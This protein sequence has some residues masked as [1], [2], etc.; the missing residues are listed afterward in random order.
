MAGRDHPWDPAGLAAVAAGGAVLV[1]GPPGCG[2]S[3]LVAALADA[4]GGARALGLDPGNPAFGPPGA[5]AL[6]RRSAGRWRLER[7]AALC[8]LDAARFR[9]PL[10]EAARSLRPE[11]AG[12][13]LVDLPGLVR[14]VAA[15]ELLDAAVRLL[16]VAAVIWV[17]EAAGLGAEL[18]ALG[19]P[20]WRVAAPPGAHRAPPAERAR[21]RTARWARWLAGAAART[22]PWAGLRAVGTPPPLGPA[23]RGLQIGFLADGATVGL[24]EVEAADAEGLRVRVAGRT[25]PTAL[26]RDAARAPDGLLRTRARARAAAVA[27][28]APDLRPGRSAAVPGPAFRVGALDALLVNGVFGDPLLHARLRHR[29]RSL[30]F[31]LGDGARLPARIAHQ[32]TDVFVSHAH[33]DHIAGLL[34]LLRA[35]MGEAGVCRLYGPAGVA[36]HVAAQLAA[37]LW[38]RIGEG[39]PRFEVLELAEGRLR[40]FALRAGGGGP[41]LI[42]EAP[43]PDGVVLEEAGLRVRAAV[44]DHGTPVLAYAFEP[45]REVHVRRDRLAA[46]GLAPGPW[47]TELKQAV[48]AGRRGAVIALPGGGVRSAG[49]L[50]RELLL[51][52]PPR[53]LVYA[54]DLADTASNRARLV[55]LAQ[56]A[57]TLVCEAAFLEAD[58]AQAEATGHLT[59]RA[60]GEIAAAAAVARLLPFHFSR[61]YED[62][63]EAVYDEVRAAF[64][65]E[66]LAT[67]AAVQA[68]G[69]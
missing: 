23:W 68:A 39:G 62:R 56:G 7:I 48:L 36:G 49:E 41:R 38:D 52:G 5:L 4:L 1:G 22:L 42:G 32:V 44:L 18:D 6:A 16:G 21:R 50:A 64:A 51:E 40:R 46:S 55:A 9:L 47:L 24:G 3:T 63:P 11:E 67:S 45:A 60:C 53:R 28:A 54:T 27:A 2:K 69:S 10:A 17:G 57:H 29:R 19:V 58:R 37:V 61:R 8:T 20:L 34:W 65:G 59:A 43:R 26:V 14:G 13:L 30:L 15:A 33:L 12:P 25:S 35:R 31:D 66:V